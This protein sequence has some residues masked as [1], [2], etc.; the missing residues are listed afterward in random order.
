[1]SLGFR[2]QELDGTQAI[3]FLDLA[4]CS[5]RQEFLEQR[6]GFILLLVRNLRLIKLRPDPRCLKA[7]D[8]QLR[9]VRV[10]LGPITTARG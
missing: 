5:D 4:P 6:N 10:G 7:L 1:M 3:Q 9:Q 2:A 8:D